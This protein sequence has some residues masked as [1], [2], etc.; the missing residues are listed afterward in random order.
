M[1]QTE[2]EEFEFRRRLED[3]Q[4]ASRSRV[5]A[6]KPAPKPSFLDKYGRDIATAGGGILGGM[7]AAPAALAASPS[8]VGPV[9]I[10]ASGVGLGAATGGAAYD[11]LM[12]AMQKAPQRTPGQVVSQNLK[13]IAY[14]AMAVPMGVVA[15]KGLQNT[16]SA[17]AQG[18][19]RFGSFVDAGAKPAAQSVKSAATA[20][21]MAQ[22][23]A[24]AD[25]Q[26]DVAARKTA[27]A[28]LRPRMEVA[29][30]QKAAQ[31]IG[32]SDTQEA[33]NLVANLQRRLRPNDPVATIPNADQAKS[34]QKVI[35][36]LSPKAGSKPNLETV[37]NL[38]RELATAYDG[39]QT[40]YAAIPKATR[41]ELVKALNNVENSYT[42]GLQKPVQENYEALMASKKQA[43]EL[44]KFAPDLQQAVTKMENMSS[45]DSVKVARSIVDK[46]QKRGMIPQDEY[47]DF[48]KLAET[49]KDAAGK[50]AFRKKMLLIGAG[51]AGLSTPIGHAVLRATGVP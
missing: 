31:G 15:A 20:K 13:D 33:K 49:A 21:I 26:A 3:E 23:K 2:E 28:T 24:L 14:N 8:V 25:A 44:E 5:A 42:E 43:K 41:K 46:M 45:A 17:L 9:A 34:Y 47:E 40:G 1:A 10:E 38:R 37:Q 12:R 6:P 39:D 7:V 4:A 11:A 35:D 36:V 22:Q 32:V 19:K 16:G 50:S 30:A 51:A 18:L 27:D 29:A 48:V